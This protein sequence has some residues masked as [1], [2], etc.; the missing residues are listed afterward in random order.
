PSIK[1][2][3]S[4]I[5]IQGKKIAYIM[6]AGDA[7]PESLEQ[8]GYQVDM[9]NPKDIT[10]VLLNNYDAVV[11]GIRAYNVNKTLKFKQAILFDFVEKGGNLVVQYNTVSLNTKGPVNIAP[12]PLELSRE[13]V[14]NENAKVNFIAPNHPILNTPNK[15]T[16]K[17]FQ[18][19]VQERGL[20]FAGK[21]SKEFD[22]IISMN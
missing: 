4:D 16:S 14:T 15:I 22:P 5:K 21:W 17:D 6:G 9:I 12:Y 8:I 10:S 13:R 3:R 7:V 11:V 19:W 2:V 20:Y 1:V 18:G